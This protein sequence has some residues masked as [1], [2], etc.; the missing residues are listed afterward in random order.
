[1]LETIIEE[2]QSVLGKG[3]EVYFDEAKFNNFLAQNQKDKSVVFIEEYRQGSYD[4]SYGVSRTDNISLYLYDSGNGKP[5]NAS[6]REEIRS[7]IEST[8]ILPL[9][10]Y[11]GDRLSNIRY[12]VGPSKYSSLETGISISINLKTEICYD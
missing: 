9:V 10:S 4:T 6:K 12:T 5:I 2:I 1:M 3:F 8:I 11:F 7:R